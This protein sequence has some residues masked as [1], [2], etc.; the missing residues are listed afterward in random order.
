M[1]TEAYIGRVFHVEDVDWYYE[2]YDVIK[3][4][5]TLETDY[6]DWLRMRVIHGTKLNQYK[7]LDEP[8]EAVVHDSNYKL[9]EGD[10]KMILQQI[11]LEAKM[12]DYLDE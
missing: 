4:F 3:A 6:Q 5:K 7:T 10:A 9:L 11:E 12:K 2:V 1:E 8:V